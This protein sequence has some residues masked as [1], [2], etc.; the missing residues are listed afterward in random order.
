[1]DDDD[2]CNSLGDPLVIWSSSASKE[3]KQHTSMPSRH[4]I[5]KWVW[6]EPRVARLEAERRNYLKVRDCLKAVIRDYEIDRASST[7]TN[8]AQAAG[9][10]IFDDPIDSSDFT[11]PFELE[12]DSALIDKEERGNQWSCRYPA[13]TTTLFDRESVWVM[14]QTMV[15][16]GSF[17][18]PLGD[19]RLLCMDFSVYPSFRG[20]FECDG[21]DV[22]GKTCLTAHLVVAPHPLL[23]Q[24]NDVPK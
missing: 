14:T 19:R 18:R 24:N 16:I 22:K 6:A 8:R 15:S 1:M 13:R 12:S 3:E 7:L 5:I 11:A 21:R 9:F 17:Q 2:Q 23:N 4:T 20:R 10:G